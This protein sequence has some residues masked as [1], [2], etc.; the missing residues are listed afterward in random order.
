MSGKTFTGVMKFNEADVEI[1]GTAA[2]CLFET[3]V[4]I[5]GYCIK[6]CYG[7]K[8][9]TLTLTGKMFASGMTEILC[10]GVKR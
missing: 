6:A 10:F 8:E 3:R 9:S 7:V 5:E 1:N 2:R 4:K